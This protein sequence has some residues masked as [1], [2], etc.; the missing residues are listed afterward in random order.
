MGRL[1]RARR[2]AAGRGPERRRPDIQAGKTL[3]GFRVPVVVASP[4]SRGNATSPRINSQTFDHTSVL[5]LIEWR[6][7]LAPLTARDASN[8]V[9]NLVDVLDFDHADPSVPALPQTEFPPISPCIALPTDEEAAFTAL[10]DRF[11]GP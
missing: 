9:G 10:R 5:K 2:A 7:S 1:L 8:D 6:W 4:W 11:F 3:L